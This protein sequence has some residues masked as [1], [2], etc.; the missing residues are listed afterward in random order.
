MGE[1]DLLIEQVYS[2]ITHDEYPEGCTQ[3]LYIIPI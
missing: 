1:S 2:Y 3:N